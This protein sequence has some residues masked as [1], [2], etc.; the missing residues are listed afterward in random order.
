MVELLASTEGVGY[1]MVMA[2]Q[3]FQLDVMIATMIVIGIIGFTLDK[4]LAQAETT[5]A[6][7]YGGAT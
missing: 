6:R 5:L 3:L 2:R 4:L 1:Q 7:R